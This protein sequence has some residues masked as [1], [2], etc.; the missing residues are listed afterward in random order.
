M[1]VI[2]VYPVVFSM[3]IHICPVINP[4]KIFF[5]LF[6]QIYPGYFWISA[7]GEHP[8]S[9]RRI[10]TEGSQCNNNLHPHVGIRR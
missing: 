3:Y 8:V 4:L 1:L 6:I 2:S 5:I 7:W 9:R 10:R